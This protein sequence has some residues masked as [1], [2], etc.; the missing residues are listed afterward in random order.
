MLRTLEPWRR[1]QRAGF[2]ARLKELQEM[3]FNA[4]ARGQ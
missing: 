4:D 3:E 2:E 1:A